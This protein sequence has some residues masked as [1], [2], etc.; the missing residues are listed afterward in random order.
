MHP[1]ALRESIFQIGR[2]SISGI[3]M[4]GPNLQK[5]FLVN[6]LAAFSLNGGQNMMTRQYDC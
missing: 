1:P 6:L 4:D 2:S 3:T 5:K